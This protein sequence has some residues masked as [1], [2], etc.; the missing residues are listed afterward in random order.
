M[1]DGRERTKKGAR[2]AQRPQESH[3]E[4][5]SICALKILQNEQS[6]GLER[7]GESEKESGKEKTRME[8]KGQA[9]LIWISNVNS[10]LDFNHHLT[11]F[12]ILKIY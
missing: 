2:M 8:T 5:N 11:H 1:A 3:G 6:L 7:D 4:L 9:N 10:R 12:I